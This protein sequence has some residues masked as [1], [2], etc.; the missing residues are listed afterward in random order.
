MVYTANWVIMG[1]YI[2]P[3]PP[4][5]HWPFFHG[6][7]PAR[8]WTLTLMSM[9]AFRR[10]SPCSWRSSTTR[11]RSLSSA[12]VQFFQGKVSNLK[13]RVFPTIGVF[14]PNHPLTNRVFRYEPSIGVP[15]FFWKHPDEWWNCETEWW[16]FAYFFIFYPEN[17][18][19]DPIWGAYFFKWVVKN[20]HLDFH[21]F[22]HRFFRD[23]L[24]KIP[25]LQR[26]LCQF[27]SGLGGRKGDSG[28]P[29]LFYQIYSSASP[30]PSRYCR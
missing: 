12:W 19:N 21:F 14:P 24:W 13:I 15:L 1:D 6:E 25:A 17:W 20:H 26:C 11:Q 28:V 22:S 8:H 18:G 27:F 7:K 30:T 23:D 3:I 29:L 4:W 5:I 16:N 2:S 10:V 9:T